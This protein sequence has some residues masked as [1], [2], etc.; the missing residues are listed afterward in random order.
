MMNTDYVGT[1]KKNIAL[2]DL[3]AENQSKD[4][5]DC[6]NFEIKTEK[7]ELD[8]QPDNQMRGIGTTFEENLYHC[9]YLTGGAGHPGLIV[10][11]A[12][13]ANIKPPLP[14]YTA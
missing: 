7:Y 9:A 3:F 4:K 13:L 2:N 14:I 5:A 6:E 8:T 1:G 12:G 10:E 11:T